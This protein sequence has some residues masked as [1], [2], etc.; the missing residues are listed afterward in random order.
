MKRVKKE[1]QEAV[2]LFGQVMK[3][4]EPQVKALRNSRAQKEICED[5]IYGLQTEVRLVFSARRN[6]EGQMT[7]KEAF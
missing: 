2:G 1:E 6:G 4:K 5:K 7:Q 3:F